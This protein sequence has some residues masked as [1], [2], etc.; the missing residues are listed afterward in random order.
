MD[1]DYRELLLGCGNNRE[2]KLWVHDRT[3]W[4]DL[5]TLDVDEACGPDVVWDLNRV[6]LP[7]QDRLFDEV[8]A[9]E[10]L[11]HLGR[12]GDYE[13]F[14]ATF[15]EIHRILKPGGFFFATV[16]WWESVWAWADPGHTRV[17]PPE[18][19]VFLDQRAYEEQVGVTEMSDYRRVWKGDLRTVMSERQGDKHVFVLMRPEV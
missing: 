9:Y 6:D 2:K 13:S 17:I 14:F 11:E 5:T 4:S 8:H 1:D 18:M 3:E 10:V 7:F 15:R 19:L 12:Q 16:P